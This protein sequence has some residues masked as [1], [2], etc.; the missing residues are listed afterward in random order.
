M[1]RSNCCRR[2]ELLGEKSIL[3]RSV[4]SSFR[5]A[6]DV[7]RRERNQ[8]TQTGAKAVSRMSY[9]GRV[10]R[11]GRR[12]CRQQAASPP[13]NIRRYGEGAAANSI[14]YARRVARLYIP[15]D[16]VSLNQPNAWLSYF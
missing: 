5:P 6:K 12:R 2:A 14:L 3:A 15:D 11:D 9:E 8:V 7:S 13:D 16:A 4:L 1:L 10:R